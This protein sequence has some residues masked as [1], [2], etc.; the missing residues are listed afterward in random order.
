[1]NQSVEQ[2]RHTA[3]KIV[4]GELRYVGILHYKAAFKDV[5]VKI[6]RSS[7]K[8]GNFKDE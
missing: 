3:G 7:L 4:A 8:R 1:M 5:H 2:L 6:T